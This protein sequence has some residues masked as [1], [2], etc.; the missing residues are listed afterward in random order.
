L[1]E[2]PGSHTVLRGPLGVCPPSVLVYNVIETMNLYGLSF[3]FS[4]RL[5]VRRGELPPSYLAICA[6]GTAY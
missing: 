1:I 2:G 6:D 5:V 3:H 4:E